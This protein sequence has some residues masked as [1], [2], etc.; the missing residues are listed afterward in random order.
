MKFTGPA[1]V[2]LA[3]ALLCPL[4]ACQGP[5]GSSNGPAAV[6][7]A[8]AEHDEARAIDLAQ[9][10][11]TLY[12]MNAKDIEQGGGGSAPADRSNV[13]VIQGHLAHDQGTFSD[14]RWMAHQLEGNAWQVIYAYKFNNIDY[15]YRF[16]VDIGSGKVSLR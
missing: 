11:T 1:R 16:L 7:G 6:S 3:I 12:D 15:S 10:A 9:K 5:A 4:A 13:A 2:L 14:G 8:Q